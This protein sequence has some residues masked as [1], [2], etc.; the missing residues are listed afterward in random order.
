MHK[1]RLKLKVLKQKLN[2]DNGPESIADWNVER[3]D[4]Q[5]S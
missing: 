3:N 5:T 4:S 2:H 1:F